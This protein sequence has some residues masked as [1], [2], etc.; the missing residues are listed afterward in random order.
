MQTVAAVGHVCAFA[1]AE[2]QAENCHFGWCAPP[3]FFFVVKM[4]ALY[5]VIYGNYKPLLDVLKQL[6]W[7]PSKKQKLP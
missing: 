6:P 1:Y 7:C 3:T 5:T 4:C 2:T